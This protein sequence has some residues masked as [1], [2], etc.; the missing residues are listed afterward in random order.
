MYIV[1]T[2]LQVVHVNPSPVINQAQV[3]LQGEFE[4]ETHLLRVYNSYGTQVLTATFSGRAYTLDM[5]ALPQ[6]TY[7]INVDGATAKTIKL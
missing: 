3:K 4:S 6:G 5:S 7:L 1:T 2:P